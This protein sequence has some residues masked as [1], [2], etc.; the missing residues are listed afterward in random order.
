VGSDT[1]NHGR[2]RR[3]AGQPAVTP[4][5]FWPTPSERPGK[6]GDRRLRASRMNHPSVRAS[7][8][9]PTLVLGRGYDLIDLSDCDNGCGDGV[10]CAAC[11]ADI[12]AE[13]LHWLRELNVPRSSG[14]GKV[15][16]W[17]RAWHRETLLADR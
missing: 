6:R 13:A 12:R 14:E 17:S 7:G 8:S 10:W 2:I 3:P 4:D 15:L 11:R 5:M 1:G 9:E 16:S